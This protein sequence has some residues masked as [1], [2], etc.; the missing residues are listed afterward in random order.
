M[1]P[2]LLSKHG[3]FFDL[4]LMFV[5]G[6]WRILHGAQTQEVH[7]EDIITNDKH[8]RDFKLRKALK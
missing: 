2:V 3:R 8:R 1:K 7:G 6:L 4:V 5:I